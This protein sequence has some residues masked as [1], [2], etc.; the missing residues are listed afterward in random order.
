[1]RAQSTT[2]PAP[3]TAQQPTKTPVSLEDSPVFKRLPPDQQEWVKQTMDR[4]NKAVADKDLAAIDQIQQDIAKHQQANP[5][6]VPA[7][8]PAQKQ[9]PPPA[10]VAANA[11]AAQSGCDATQPKKPRFS[12]TRAMQ[13]AVTRQAAAISGKT[14][15][16]V[17]PNAPA[18]VINDAQG[19]PCPPAPNAAPKAAPK[20]PRKAVRQ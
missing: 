6:V 7:P 9:T 20:K 17:D 1:M 13:D 11:K 15:I 19:N 3:Q 4:L 5:P 18:Q 2:Q 8:A 10:N 14:G 12:L 16:A